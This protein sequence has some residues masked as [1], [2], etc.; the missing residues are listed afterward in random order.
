ML[1]PAGSRLP[2]WPAAPLVAVA[3]AVVRWVPGGLPG[4]AMG[5]AGVA[6]SVQLLPRIPSCWPL[7]LVSVPDARPLSDPAR[8]V[9][10]PVCGFVGYPF[11][12]LDGVCTSV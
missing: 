6:G 4:L 7:A 11:Q 5:G 1:A 2:R 3:V 12:F 10:S 9:L 8:E